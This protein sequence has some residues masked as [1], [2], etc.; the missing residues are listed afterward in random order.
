MIKKKQR[1]FFRKPVFA[2]DFHTEATQ[3]ETIKGQI[4]LNIFIAFD[5]SKKEKKKAVG[6]LLL[7]R[8]FVTRVVL[9]KRTHLSRRILS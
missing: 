6:A 4:K 7:Q 3:G 2:C 5:G 9:R 1:K 8:L